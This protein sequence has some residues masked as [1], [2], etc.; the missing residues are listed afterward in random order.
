MTDLRDTIVGIINN[1][2]CDIVADVPE[3]EADEAATDAILEFLM[4]QGLKV[5]WCRDCAAGRMGASEEYPWKCLID[6]RDVQ[7]GTYPPDWCPL[8]P[9]TG[10]PVLLWL[11]EGGR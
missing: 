4:G 6:Q 3:K 1:H 11:D 8:R 9:E 10:G 2:G 7:R 5:Y